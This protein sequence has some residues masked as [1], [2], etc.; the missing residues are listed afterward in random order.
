MSIGKVVTPGPVR[1]SET[2][3]WLNEVTN[4]KIK[5][6]RMPC[7]MLGNTM[8]KKVRSRVAPSMTAASSTSG[9]RF[10]RLAVTTRTAYGTTSTVWANTSARVTDMSSGITA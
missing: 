3:T 10:S 8:R 6:A 7:T 1:K 9:R 2:G 4:P 5:A